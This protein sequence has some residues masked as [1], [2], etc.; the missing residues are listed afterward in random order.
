MKLR[1]FLTCWVLFAL[2]FATNVVREHYPAFSLIEQGNFQLDEYAGLHADI[3][4]HTDGH[5]YIGNQVLCSVFAAVPLLAFDPVLDWLTEIRQRQKRDGTA[6]KGDYDTQ[7]PNRAKFFRIVQERGWDLRF[8]AATAITSA[9]F[10]AP[11]AA[12]IAVWIFAVLLRR[13]VEQRRALWLALLFALGTPLF[14]RAASLN[15]NMLMTAAVF[16]SFVLLWLRPDGK[17]PVSS[18]RA[19]WAGIFAGGG[20]AL[21]YAAVITLLGVF[22]YLLWTHFRDFGPAAMGQAAVSFIC[23]TLPPVAFLWWSQWTMYGNPFLPGQF[24]MPNQNKYVGE[25]VR[26]FTAPDVGL[27]FDN[28]FDP[29]YGMFVFGPLLLLALVPV[30]RT[31]KELIV[32]RRER[33]FLWLL[34][35]AFLVFCACNQYSRLQW[36]TG[37]RYLLPLVPL[38]FLMLSDHLARMPRAVL[39]L[40]TVTSVAHTWVLSMTRYL[41]DHGGQEDPVSVLPG[42]WAMVV[43]DGVQFPWLTVLRSSPSLQHP[44]VQ[45]WWLPYAMLALVLG[46]VAWI[47]RMGRAPAVR[48]THPAG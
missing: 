32:P 33:G 12:G 16:G 48:A 47:W 21:D 2:H 36:N 14:Y 27:F 29:D 25:G 24:W 40:L 44:I 19:F 46:F 11:L 39:T 41:A 3:F 7:Y 18:V 5:H 20:L 17:R 45:A 43:R 28:L 15:H 6:P 37:F 22:G 9:F 38:L 4:E 35:L 30:V 23:G 1:L 34:I 31:G 13:G 8:G 10:M 26:G 42:S